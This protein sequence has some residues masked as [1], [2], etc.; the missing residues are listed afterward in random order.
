MVVEGAGKGVAPGF[1]PHQFDRFSQSDAP[2]TRLHRGLGLG[3]SIVEHLVELHGGSASTPPAR[4]KEE[5]PAC[6]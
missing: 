2:G 5:A 1:L 4:G 3:L 6:R